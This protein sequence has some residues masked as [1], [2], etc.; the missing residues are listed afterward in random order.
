VWALI[1][2]VREVVLERRGVA[3]STEVR[4]LGFPDGENGAM[5]LGEGDDG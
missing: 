2:H 5:V 4:L 1:N 3:L